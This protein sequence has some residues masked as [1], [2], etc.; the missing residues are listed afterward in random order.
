MRFNYLRRY[1]AW[2]IVGITVAAVLVR[3]GSISEIPP[4]LHFDEAFENVQ[5]LRVLETGEYPVFFEGN[6]GVEPTFIY[7][8]ALFYRLWGPSPAAGRLVAA[9]VGVVTV[10]A[11]YLF[12]RAA[13]R[14]TGRN[15]AILLA[16][17]SSLTLAF[18]YWHIHF[19]RLGIEPILVPL[20]AVIALYLLCL[21]LRTGRM[22]AFVLCGAAVGFGP[23]TYP[24]GRLLPLLAVLLTLHF[25]LTQKGNRS[26][27][28]ALFPHLPGLIAAVVTA[29]L[30]LLPLALYFIDHPTLLFQR[31]SQVGVVAEGQGSESPWLTVAENAGASFEMYNFSGDSDPRNNLPGRPVLDFFW[32]FFFWLGIS[33]CLLYLRYPAYGMPLWWLIV[34]TLPTVFSEYA[35][36]FRRAL[37]ASPAVAL[38]VAIGVVS[39]IEWIVYAKAFLF[40]EKPDTQPFRVQRSFVVTVFLA[41]SVL[42]VPGAVFSVRDYFAV[43]ARDPALFYAFDVGLKRI[44][45][46]VRELPE[47]EVAYLSPVR[48]DHQTLAFFVGREGHPKTFDGRKVV[49]LPPAGRGA[50]Y[51]NLV[52]EDRVLATKLLPYL[53]DLTEDRHFRDFAG[54]LYAVVRRIPPGAPR[55]LSPSV[56]VNANLNDQVEILGCEIGARSLS[57]G[58]TLDVTVFWRALTSMTKDYTA[59]V[60]LVGPYNPAADGPLWAQDDTQPGRGS[61]PTSRWTPDEVVIETYRL[62][63]PA[64]APSDTFFV[65]AGM[66]WLP[67]LERLPVVDSA[68]GAA[69][70][71]V[72]A[73]VRVTD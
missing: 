6:Y 2:I 57:P 62:K 63:V 45:E 10:P 59:F 38:L 24:A 40:V 55:L 69:D 35:P 66:Y 54:G 39:L 46:Y 7:L 68:R 47:R 28:E 36:H 58:D 60:H 67:S 23:Y 43:W 5:A 37:G 13:F 44:A 30:V 34:M 3:F 25:L 51:I 9:A 14:R 32:S 41:V 27:K 18:L 50:T 33:T 20:N 48:Q 71:V 52:E 31:M 49:V 73:R 64:V 65:Q 22:W 12:V 19:S 11:F 56:L 42:W 1:E 15:R 26:L 53:P 8:I 61:Y 29:L 70:S 21:G 72:L 17:F 4:G 16:S